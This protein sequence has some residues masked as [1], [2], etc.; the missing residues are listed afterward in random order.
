MQSLGR[1]LASR[2]QV[3]NPDSSSI[4]TQH[5]KTK[6]PENRHGVLRV[7]NP[8]LL[9]TD[10]IHAAFALVQMAYPSARLPSV[11]LHP[12]DKVRSCW[13]MACEAELEGDQ[14]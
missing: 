10:I 14:Q 9:G 4:Q 1:Q 13:A 3:W 2:G 11:G 6:N 7:K 8:P 5:I 12:E